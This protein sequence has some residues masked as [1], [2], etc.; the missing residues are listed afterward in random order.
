MCRA[1]CDVRPGGVCA[2]AYDPVFRE[3]NIAARLSAAQ[4]ARK[5]GIASRTITNIEAIGAD[6]TL[7]KWSGGSYRITRRIT[8]RR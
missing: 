8:R 4:N 5:E 6:K 1:S 3:L 2:E 7:T